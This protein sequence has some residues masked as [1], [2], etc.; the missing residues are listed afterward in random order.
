MRLY[1]NFL[2]RKGTT[3]VVVSRETRG[4][5]LTPKSSAPQRVVDQLSVR[6]AACLDEICQ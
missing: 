4:D 1:E 6:S 2:K 3:R 5:F